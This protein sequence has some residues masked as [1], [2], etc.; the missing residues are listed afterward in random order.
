[1]KSYYLTEKED[2]TFTKLV[3]EFNEMEKKNDS[4]YAEMENR[5]KE[6][7]SILLYMIP[8]YR[9]Y[10]QEED[11]GEFFLDIQKDIDWI[12]RSFRISGLTYNGYLTQ[13]CRYR[14]MRFMR[15]KMK[16]AN[17]ETAI[18]FSDMTIHESLTSENCLPYSA[19]F[20][21]VSS[22]DLSQLS[23]HIIR[24]QSQENMVF[25]EKE[26]HVTEMLRKTKKRLQFVSL[27]LSLPETETPGF[28]AGVSRLLRI[29]IDTA[30]RFYTLRHEMLHKNNAKAIEAL[31]MIAGRHWTLLVKMRRAL[32]LETDDE[33][34][35]QLER[36]YKRLNEIYMHRR[37]EIARAHTGLTHKAISEL[38]GI[39]RSSVSY[40]IKAMRQSLEE[41]TESL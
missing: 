12:I 2:R 36:K 15:R 1:M 34:K 40:S 30:S 21:D 25:N 33:K 26:L 7:T 18:I 27:L 8:M 5:I 10:L 22:M 37:K 28:I 13:I 4:L 17:L 20:K 38:L 3:L 39:S 6:R 9:L 23:R 32:Y 14:V 31:E 16:N 41:I 19:E 29:D 35:R 11:A 24:N